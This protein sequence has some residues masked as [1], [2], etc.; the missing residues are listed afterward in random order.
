M[1]SFSSGGRRKDSGASCDR[2]CHDASF[3]DVEPAILKAGEKVTLAS[4]VLFQIQDDLLDILA[5]SSANVR[6]RISPKERS[7]LLSQL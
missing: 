6:P 7:A 3:T 5:I 4:G 2:D 1:G